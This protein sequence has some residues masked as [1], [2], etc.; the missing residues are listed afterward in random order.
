MRLSY[1][2]STVKNHP[3]EIYKN[4]SCKLYK[5]TIKLIAIVNIARGKVTNVSQTNLFGRI[6]GS[7]CG[8]YKD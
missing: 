1:S 6:W 8:K 4:R 7:H 2:Q 5:R 3:F